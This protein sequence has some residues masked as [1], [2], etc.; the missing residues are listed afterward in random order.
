LRREPPGATLARVSGPPARGTAPTPLERLRA[1]LARRDWSGPALSLLLVLTVAVAAGALLVPGAHRLPGPDALG[2]P[3]PATLKADRDYD[4]VDA[5]ATARRRAEASAAVPPVFNQDDRAAEDAAARIRAAFELVRAEEE[6][7]RAASAPRALDARELQA[8]YAARRDAFTSR[9]QLVVRDEDFTALGG[10]RFA[11]ATER[12]LAALASEGLAGLVVADLKLLPGRGEPGFVV[13]TFRAGASQGERVVTDASAVR[14]VETARAEVARAAAARLAHESPPL[15]AAL[16]RL[17]A[18]AVHPTLE[19]DQ[20]ETERR[21][22]EA[23]AAVKPVVVRVKRGEKI[24]GDGE[25]IEKR[26]LVVFA[27]IVAQRRGEDLASVR[28]GGGAL[29]ALVVALLWTFARRNVRSFRPARRDALLLASLVVASLALGS[30]GFAVADA[31]HERFPGFPRPSLYHLVPFAAAAMIVRQVM[32]AEAALLFAFA[33]GIAA[34]LLAGQSISYAVFATLTS[35]AAAGLVGGARDRAGLFRAGAG[36][37]VVGVATVIATGLYQGQGAAELLASALAA[38]GGGAVVLPMVVIGL[39]PL[40]EGAFGYVTDVKLLELANLN[41]PALKELIVQAPG[42]Y[43]HSI[44]MGSMVESAAQAIGANPL[45]ARVCAYYHDLGKIRN[46]LYYAENQRGENRHDSIAPSMSALVIKR[47]VA[48]GLELARHWRL[49]RV[50]QDAIAQHHGTRLVG[51]FYAKAQRGEGEG[52]HPAPVDEGT[53][54]Y[55]GPRPQTRE[56]ALVMI[57]DACEAS[58]R[59]LETPDPESLRALVGRRINEVFG[60]GQLDDCEL[61]LKDLNAIGAAMVRALEAIYHTR[62]EYPGRREDGPRPPV[63]LVA[64]QP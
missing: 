9:L 11:P 18:A 38:L 23:A 32:A 4:L 46:P 8:R 40:V 2:L 26:H 59:A 14:D 35:V 31:L 15:R 43:H 17:A 53:F 33:S 61:T 39:L 51:Y 44:L 16:A 30:M 57:A 3:A 58:A 64:R 52:R 10:A 7:L 48:D 24:I 20:A 21:Q 36:V 1:Q 54:R 6:A 28:L 60:E 13:R 45:L 22:A 42:T 56:A 63:Q 12:E 62:P 49:P 37:A 47:H 19:H 50:V 34:G 29:V 41:H 25:R 5:E 55:G 27:G